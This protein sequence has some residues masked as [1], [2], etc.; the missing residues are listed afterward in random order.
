MEIVN[1]FFASGAI[2]LTFL[3]LIEEFEDTRPWN[4][5][6]VRF[7]DFTKIAWT[8]RKYWT[9]HSFSFLKFIIFDYLDFKNEI[10]GNHASY[11]I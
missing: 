10:N 3:G 4:G 5:A 9:K 6:D 8:A 7:F 2:G 1:N 11:I